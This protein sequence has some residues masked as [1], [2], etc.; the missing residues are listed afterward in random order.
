MD[1]EVEERMKEGRKE[2]RDEER[3]GRGRIEGHADTVSES[4]TC[5]GR[6]ET[7]RT[8][9][10][11]KSKPSISAGEKKKKRKREGEKHTRKHLMI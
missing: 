6:K 5:E 8:E 7:N 3:E 9:E 4:I 11:K 10:L 2:G 1:G